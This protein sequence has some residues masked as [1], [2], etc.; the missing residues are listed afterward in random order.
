MTG[1]YPRWYVVLA[2]AWSAC[3]GADNRVLHYTDMLSGTQRCAENV[4]HWSWFVHVTWRRAS[5]VLFLS[6]A[7][8]LQSI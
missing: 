2:V 3:Q 7:V 8:I 4:C 1:C 5:S 6:F